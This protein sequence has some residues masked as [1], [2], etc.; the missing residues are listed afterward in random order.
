M[1]RHDV[2]KDKHRLREQWYPQTPNRAFG[3]P[4]NDQNAYTKFTLY[5]SGLTAFVRFRKQFNIKR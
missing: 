1:K 5:G 2:K 3:I 4:D